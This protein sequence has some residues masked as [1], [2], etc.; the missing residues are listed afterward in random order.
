MFLIVAGV[1]W[2]KLRLG[3]AASRL[4]FFLAIYGCLAAWVANLLAA[5]WGAGNTIL[6]IAAGAAHGS[7]FQEIFIV[8]ALRSA[9]ISLIVSV[10]LILWGVR[11]LPAESLNT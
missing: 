7:A 2:S 3:P 9:G 8:V 11:R 10:A 1:L 5:A 4:A 6:P